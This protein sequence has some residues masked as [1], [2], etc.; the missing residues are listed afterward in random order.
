MFVF[1]QIAYLFSCRSLD[2]FR[3]TGWN[4]W[5]LGG[6]AVMIALQVSILYVP[7]M[8]ELFHTAPLTVGGWLLV[9]GLAVTT[10]LVAEVDK[11]LWRP[12]QQAPRRPAGTPGS[13]GDAVSGLRGL[14]SSRCG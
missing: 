6:V 8:N 10:F 2:R 7:L 3:P 4:P 13:G 1:A 12:G 14:L 11:F 9:L 5:V